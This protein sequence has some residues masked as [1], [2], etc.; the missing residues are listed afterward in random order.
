MYWFIFSKCI[1]KNNVYV[2][3]RVVNICVHVFFINKQSLEKTFVN[4]LL[5]L[6]LFLISEDMK[7]IYIYIQVIFLLFIEFTSNYKKTILLT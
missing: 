2:N 7:I 5:L 4:D 1:V 6:I 3:K